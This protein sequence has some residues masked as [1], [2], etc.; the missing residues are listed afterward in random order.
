[1]L[2]C[3][4]MS[5]GR[6]LQPRQTYIHLLCLFALAFN[7]AVAHAEETSLTLANAVSRTMA[8]NPSLRV[9]DLRLQGLEGSRLTANQAPAYEAGL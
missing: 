9:F 5:T 8:Q 2:F 7:V 3:K 6:R 1:M 4:P